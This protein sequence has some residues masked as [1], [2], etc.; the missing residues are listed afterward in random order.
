M[1]LA[2]RAGSMAHFLL[3]AGRVSQA[4]RH[5]TVEEIWYAIAG[6]GEMWRS[7]DSDD[8]IT[9]L[10]AG[11]CLTIPV[12]VSFQFRALGSEPF[13]AVAITMPPWPGPDEAEVVQGIWTPNLGQY[14]PVI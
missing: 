8:D 9:P 6:R 3:P 10:S 4:V 5:R 11:T 14:V 7:L 12:G 1:L 13:A 2:L